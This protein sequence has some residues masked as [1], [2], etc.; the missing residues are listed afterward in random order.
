MVEQVFESLGLGK[1]NK[2]DPGPSRKNKI[3]TNPTHPKQAAR[4]VDEMKAFLA[5]FALEVHTTRVWLFVGLEVKRHQT[6]RKNEFAHP[7]FGTT[8]KK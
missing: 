3:S 7:P 4:R 6:S 5:Q 2:F 1:L 8:T